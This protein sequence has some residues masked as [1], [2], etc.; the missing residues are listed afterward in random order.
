MKENALSLDL[1]SGKINLD[2]LTD[3]QRQQAYNELRPYAK[4]AEL[5]KEKEEALRKASQKIIDSAPQ[6]VN[7]AIAQL[8]RGDGLYNKY[9]CN[10][11]EMPKVL[12]AA[13]VER[14]EMPVPMQDRYHL[15]IVSPDGQ[16]T[17]WTRASDKVVAER[18]EQITKSTIAAV[19][20]EAQDFYAKAMAKVPEQVAKGNQLFKQL[21]RER[22]EEAKLSDIIDQALAGIEAPV[23]EVKEV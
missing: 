11:I 12:H 17:F 1:I 4:P 19:Q 7:A 20:Q 18:K 16:A 8:I 3:E 5:I 10:V 22:K 2:E 14:G 15:P 23:F 13:F 9:F 6:R 21:E